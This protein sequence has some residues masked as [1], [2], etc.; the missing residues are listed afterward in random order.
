MG[1]TRPP[2]TEAEYEAGFFAQSESRLLAYKNAQ[3]RYQEAIQQM[4]DG[5]MPPP[6]D[7]LWRDSHFQATV[8]GALHGV[9]QVEGEARMLQNLATLFGGKVPP[10]TR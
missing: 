7:P 2:G 3:L 5:K 10:L 1:M 9:K 6:D 4:M 8:A